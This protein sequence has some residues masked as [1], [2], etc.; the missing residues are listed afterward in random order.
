MGYNN[1]RKRFQT[2]MNWKQCQW[3]SLKT[4]MVKM[5]IFFYFIIYWNLSLCKPMYEE[6]LGAFLRNLFVTHPHFLHVWFW[7]SAWILHVFSFSQYDSWFLYDQK[8]QHSEK[9]YLLRFE[10]PNTTSFGSK[11]LKV[12]TQWFWSCHSHPKQSRCFWAWFLFNYPH[13]YTGN[14][15]CWIGFFFVFLFLNMIADFCMTRK[16]STVKWSTFSGLKCLTPLHF[17]ARLWRLL[18]NDSDLITVIQNNL[19]VFMHDFFQ[20]FTF[21]TIIILIFG[22]KFFFVLLFLNIHAD[23]CMTRSMIW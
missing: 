15:D 11:A 5:K 1:T 8:E 17:A 23:F 16:S 2:F 13:F 10:M 6:K 9:E 18:L 21:F 12:V 14:F 19:G 20:L 4:E 3:T 7:L 22:L